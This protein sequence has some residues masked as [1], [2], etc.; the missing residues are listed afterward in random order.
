MPFGA[1]SIGKVYLQSKF[2]FT[3][4]RNDFSCECTPGN[5]IRESLP[6]NQKKFRKVHASRGKFPPSFFFF[7]FC[8]ERKLCFLST[9]KNYAQRNLFEILIDQIEI[10][11]YLPFFDWFGTANGQ[12]PFA[13][14]NQSGNGKYNQIS[15]WFDKISKR[16]LCV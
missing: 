16:F 14:P 7:S 2:G 4:F 13:I 12:C 3:R 8:R 15:V 10:R 5:A 1:K 6:K 11:L 9:W